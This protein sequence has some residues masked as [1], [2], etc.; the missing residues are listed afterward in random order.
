M[1]DRSDKCKQLQTLHDRLTVE[2]STLRQSKEEEE[3][4]GV[5]N[6]LVMT[7]IIKHLQKALSEV[8]LELEKCQA[9]H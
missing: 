3:R 6:P 1:N 2:L 7:N 4:E 8:E 5:E 9:S